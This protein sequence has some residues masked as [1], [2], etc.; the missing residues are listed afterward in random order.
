MSTPQHVLDFNSDRH[1]LHFDDPSF[2]L[3]QSHPLYDETVKKPRGNAT[4]E[5]VTFLRAQT[6]SDFAQSLADFHDRNG[7][8]TEKQVASAT[9]MKAKID[10]RQAEKTSS[11]PAPDSGLDLTDLPSGYYGVPQGETRLKVRVNQVTSGKWAGWTFV[12]DG[13]EYGAQ[14]KYGA[15]RP[16]QTYQGQIQDQLRRIMEDVPA[17]LKAYGDLTGRC[18]I[19]NRKLED[20]ESVARG[21]GP[22]CFANM[23]L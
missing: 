8:L 5:L 22:I 3:G 6:W 1:G 17:A 10:A 15:Q 18:G 21:I 23:D 14:T 20:E 4:T 2:V 12:D 16:G 11:A 13:A 9:S 7:Y 19:C